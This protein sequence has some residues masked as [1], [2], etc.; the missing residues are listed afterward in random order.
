MRLKSNS[1]Y[2]HLHNHT[3]YSPFDGA[4]KMGEW[5]L[6]AR[7]MGFKSLAISDHGNIGG[8]IK[9]YQE[10]RRKK[11]KEDKELLGLDGK[12][13]PTIK[14][15][16]GMEAYLARNIKEKNPDQRKGN[17]HLLLIAKNK[18]GYENLCALA[19]LA[20]VE[21]R[22]IDPRID[23]DNL[24][25]HSNGLI[26]SSACLSSVINANLMHGR[27]D[28][29]KAVATI[30]KDIFGRDFFLEVMYHGIDAEGLIIPDVLR[31][32]KMLDIPVIASNDCHYCRKEQARSQEVLMAMST[33]RCI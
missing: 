16:F 19:Q 1:N 23:L 4:N 27:F 12:P 30:F 32:G 20:Q 21:G 29:A 24:A 2:T 15:I 18:D 14:P 28:Q 25:K 26:C 8:W 13:L 22:Y 31:L 17:R 3:E 6:H 7:R 5:V 11:D 10:C 9:F 33:S